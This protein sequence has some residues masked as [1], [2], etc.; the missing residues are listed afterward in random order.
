MAPGPWSAASARFLQC[1]YLFIL[2]VKERRRPGPLLCLMQTSDKDD[3]ESDKERWIK[4]RP[5]WRSLRTSWL[6]RCP[7]DVDSAK[8]H[9]VV[10]APLS[11][12]LTA[13]HALAFWMTI[14]Y[15][16]LCG[17]IITSSTSDP[18]FYKYP[19]HRRQWPLMWKTLSS[20]HISWE[21]LRFE[22]VS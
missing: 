14:H 17:L 11:G 5:A 3:K 12:G 1:M 19:W 7:L 16:P 13:L 2:P 18:G 9:H 6:L 4:R 10:W 20:I 22:S 8:G 15:T 21:L